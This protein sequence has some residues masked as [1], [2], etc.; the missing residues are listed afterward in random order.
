MPRAVVVLCTLLSLTSH[1]GVTVPADLGIGPEAL[2]F[3]GPLLDNRGALPHF[4]LAFNLYAIIDQQTVKQNWDRIPPKYRG[5]AA[6]VTEAHVGPSIFIPQTLIISP[7]VAELGGVGMYGATWAPLGLTLL[8]N[9]PPDPREWNKSRGRYS[10]DA[11]VLLTYLFIHSDFADIPPTHFLRPGLELKLTLLLSL[12]EKVLVSFGG[13][14]QFYVPQVIGTF[15]DVAPLE[16]SVW[17]A[18]FA[19]LKLHFRFPYEVA[20]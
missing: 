16:Q 4:A 17:L 20:L 10:L 13:G 12:S 1:A 15:L 9:P 8:S 6:G 2:W 14:A 5:L 7:K 19:F 11:N 18:G 3:P